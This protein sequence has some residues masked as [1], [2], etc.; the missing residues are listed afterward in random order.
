MLEI[1]KQSPEIVGNI[2][3]NDWSSD[4]KYFWAHTHYGAVALGFIRINTG[5]WQADFISAPK[6]VLG[7]DPLN[8]NTGYI[9]IHPGNIWIGVQELNEEE[10][11]RRRK[12]GIGTELYVQNL[13]TSE[14]YFVA[15]TDEPLWYFKP[16][17]IS[18]TE[19]Q[20]ELPTGEKKIYKIE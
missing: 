16:K 8:P 2:S 3:L 5:E 13:I 7:G 19:L 1:E 9:T 10:K 4:G 14:R 17:W 20:Y 18:D 6:D 11:A 12:E 15:R